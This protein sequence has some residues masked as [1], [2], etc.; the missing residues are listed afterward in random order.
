MNFLMLEVPEILHLALALIIVPKS[1]EFD[2]EFLISYI[3]FHSF[4]PGSILRV[5]VNNLMYPEV[6]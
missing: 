1:D 3:H 2:L 5:I 6:L 4:P